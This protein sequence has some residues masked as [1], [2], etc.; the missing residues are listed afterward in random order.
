MEHRVD[1]TEPPRVLVVDDDRRNW[2]LAGAILEGD[3]YAVVEAADGAG[4]LATFS[5]RVVDLVLL[6]VMMPGIDGF[7]V[8][9]RLRATVAGARVPII[10]LTSLSDLK[11]HGAALD[12]GGDD[13]LTKP[14]DRVG[15]LIRVRSLLRLA[16]LRRELQESHAVV[17]NQR[18]ALLAARERQRQLAAMVVHDFKNPLTGIVMCADHLGATE[19]LSPTGRE[20]LDDLL[21]S[22]EAMSGLV[23]NILDIARALDGRLQPRLVPVN[24]R[25]VWE[26][27][28]DRMS[29]RIARSGLAVELEMEPGPLVISGDPVLVRRICENL[30]D[31]A[32]RYG[33]PAS[34]VSVRCRSHRG[35]VQFEVA[36]RGPGVPP[37]QRERIFEPWDRAGAGEGEHA[38]R[39][40][41][42]S[43]CRLA[44]EAQGGRI[45]VVEAGP[46][47]VF[48][49]W[50]PAPDAAAEPATSALSSSGWQ[51]TSLDRLRAADPA[52]AWPAAPAGPSGEEAKLDVAPRDPGRVLLVDD[53]P[54]LLRSL[55]RLLAPAGHA[56]VC[57]SSA[58]AALAML[59]QREFDV[60]VTDIHMPGMSGLDL[61]AKVRSRPQPLPVVLV[62]A[63][64]DI[65]SALRAVEA[66]A[67]RYLIRPADDSALRSTV[68]RAVRM[69]RFSRIEQELAGHT[70]AATQ[71]LERR[72]ALGSELHRTLGGLRLAWQPIVRWS[73]R[74]VVAYEALMRPQGGEL[75]HPG[76]VLEAAEDLGR[77]ADVAA[78]VQRRIATE[79][80][81]APAAV[82]LFVNLHP[83]DLFDD[84]LLAQDGPLVPFAGRICLEITERAALDRRLDEVQS[85]VKRLRKLGFR[86]VVDDLGA[87][88]AGL[89]SFAQLAPDVVKLDLSLVRDVHLDP[90]RQR[91]IR[92]MFELCVDLGIDMVAEGVE[93]LEE[94][95][96]LVALGCDL[97]QGYLFARPEFGFP[98]PAP[99][100]LEGPA[101]APQRASG[102]AHR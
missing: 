40:L 99:R 5:E 62:S 78:A 73:D 67:F 38:N 80:P 77:V 21:A 51:T 52:P 49:V 50:L 22:S 43:F 82:Q 30:V 19:E 54:V 20:V 47:A 14:I 71:E 85:R 56:F 97:L 87:G 95:D 1:V 3:G 81:E 24:L 12:S 42:L 74:E 102:G 17:S 83:R 33:P 23:T 65:D 2:L 64:P 36:D 84:A 16:E 93:T 90:V 58:E 94:R 89:A 68:A 48:R 72:E 91:L 86:I 101:A 15:L 10:F 27:V 59:E 53:D 75:P 41:G 35:G 98:A 57:A 76:A 9:R 70:R 29:L 69:A 34:V 63:N 96:C 100:S 55:R 46:G 39:G 25:G 4:A 61:L 66:G 88:Y 79:A 13:F 32:L 8:A 26:A 37:E 31:N 44:A 60:V 11:T 18:D 45:E 92:S 28:L 7:E 6:D